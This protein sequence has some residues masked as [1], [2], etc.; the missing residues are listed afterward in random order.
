MPGRDGAEQWQG[1]GPNPRGQLF[2]HGPKRARLMAACL[3]L[4][5]G[6]GGKLGLGFKGSVPA[7]SKLGLLGFVFGASISLRRAYGGRGFFRLS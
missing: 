4:G 3:G 7:G 1:H 2:A 5:I 6:G